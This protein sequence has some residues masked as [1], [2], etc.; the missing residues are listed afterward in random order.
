MTE[1]FTGL[2]GLLVATTII[3]LVRQ[4]HIRA[5]YGVGWIL[6]AVIFAVLGFAPYLLDRVAYWLGVAYPP[7]VALIVGGS[8]LIIKAVVA[9]VELS[10]AETRSM[11][12]VQRVSSLEADIRNLMQHDRG[13]SSKSS[14]TDHGS[15]GTAAPDQID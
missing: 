3:Y 6:V 13:Y 2:T 4:D 12:L 5:R 1:V 8:A 15:G 11:R 14:D 10:R 7:T 9:D